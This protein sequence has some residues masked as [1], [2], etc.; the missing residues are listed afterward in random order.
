MS[1][2]LMQQPVEYQDVQQQANP[3]EKEEDQLGIDWSAINKSVDNMNYIAQQRR[4]EYARGAG[5]EAP[6]VDE[7]GNPTDANYN[8]TSQDIAKASASSY[9]QYQYNLRKGDPNAWRKQNL[10]QATK[11][12]TEILVGRALENERTKENL[13]SSSMPQEARLE[14]FKQLEAINNMSAEERLDNYDRRKKGDPNTVEDFQFE[15]DMATKSSEE[16]EALYGVTV[17]DYAFQ[18]EKQNLRLLA[19][20]TYH[21]GGETLDPSFF[22]MEN[23]KDSGLSILR[24]ASDTID[25]FSDLGSLALQGKDAIPE[26]DDGIFDN[27]SNW[28]REQQSTPHKNAEKRQATDEDYFD[29]TESDE[30]TALLREGK[31]FNEAKSTAHGRIQGDQF[32]SVFDEKSTLYTQA[33]EVLSDF[34]T[35]G[36]IAKGSAMLARGVSKEA[37]QKYVNGQVR[38]ALKDKVEAGAKANMNKAVLDAQKAVRASQPKLSNSAMVSMT[39]AQRLA[40]QRAQGTSMKQI[41]ESIRNSPLIQKATLNQSKHDARGFVKALRDKRDADVKDI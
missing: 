26:I 1:N 23:L 8:Y 22:S 2:Y 37:V 35:G 13:M 28:L 12:Q 29:K 41:E 3:T 21:T 19:D 39:P 10:E 20:R 16:L 38:D 14:Q 30:R 15:Q 36:I 34:V 32:F 40:S 11:R 31:T 4:N 7:Q 5:I 25:S 33:S 17:A 24:K 9:S 18:K 27:F 6:A